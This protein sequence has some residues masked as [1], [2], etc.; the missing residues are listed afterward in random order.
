MDTAAHQRSSPDLGRRWFQFSLRSLLIVMAIV[1]IALGTF[2][3]RLEE[4][5][6]A[7]LAVRAAGGAIR[8]QVLDSNSLPARRQ[9]AIAQVVAAEYKSAEETNRQTP[10]TYPLDEIR[11]LRE[12]WLKEEHPSDEASRPTWLPK[13]LLPDEWFQYVEE[14]DLH[15]CEIDGAVSKLQGFR[16]LRVL[17][18]SSTS[19]TDADVG[20]LCQLKSLRRLS[21]WGTK[22]S[23]DGAN[24]IQ[25]ALP[26]CLI[27][28]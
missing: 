22:I 18:L 26:D 8:S 1:A 13:G 4:Q 21:L 28:R 9:A 7:I 25:N 24:R 11:R 19:V 5:R 20:V 15:E 17:N 12:I 27:T 16:D 6:W 23:E 10:G 3:H 2:I 14:V